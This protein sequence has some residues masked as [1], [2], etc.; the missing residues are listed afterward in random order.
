MAR[1]LQAAFAVER[2]EEVLHAVAEDA[3]SPSRVEVLPWHDEAIFEADLRQAIREITEAAN[4]LLAERLTD[5]LETA[6]PTLAGR[7]AAAPRFSDPA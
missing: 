1:G 6:P 2:I 5:L 7:L 4:D 3:L